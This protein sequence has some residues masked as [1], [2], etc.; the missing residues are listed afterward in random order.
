MPFQ[1]VLVT[2]EAQLLDE[3]VEQ[4]ILPAFDGLAGIL[5]DHAPVLLKLGVAALRVDRTGSQRAFLFHRRRR[6]PDARQQADDPDAGS[7][8]RRRPRRPG[9]HG[10]LMPPPPHARAANPADAAQRDHE[11]D[12]AR[13]QSA[14]AGKSR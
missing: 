3:N 8:A 14:L 9:R 5:K 13:A 2:P 10:R 4:V 7:D 6:G 12:R 1:C 11:M